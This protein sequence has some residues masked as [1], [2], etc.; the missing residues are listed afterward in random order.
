MV[1]IAKEE[2]DKGDL[3]EDN[4]LSDNPYPTLEEVPGTEDQ[5]ARAEREMRNNTAI[6]AWRDEQHRR[7]DDEGKTFKGGTRGEADKQLKSKLFLSLGKQG[8]NYFNQKHPYRKIV[9]IIS[10]KLCKLS[11]KLS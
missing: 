3:L 4:S 8:Q 1:V 2:V 11:E 6:T 5:Q 10:I 7:A 9:N